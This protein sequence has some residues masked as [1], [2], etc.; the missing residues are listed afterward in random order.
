M[1]DKGEGVPQDC[2]QAHKWY[3][4]SASQHPASEEVKRKIAVI[5]RDNLAAQMTQAQV[6]EAQRLAR[7]WMAEFE[8]R[9]KE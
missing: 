5:L 8:K 4:L 9:R 1:Y 3:N 6:A 2:V 7:E